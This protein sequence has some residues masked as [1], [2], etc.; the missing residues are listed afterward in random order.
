M[1]RIKEIDRINL[2]LIFLFLVAFPFGTFPGFIF[3]RFLTLPL[4]LHPIDVIIFILVVINLYRFKKLYNSVFRSLI[5]FMV[6]AALTLIFSLLK[7]SLKETFTG[8]LYLIRLGSYMYF[9]LM[10]TNLVNEKKISKKLLIDS[11]ALTG[12]II[13]ILGWLQY[14]LIPDLRTLKLF[15]WDDHYFRL[16]SSF[17]DPGFTGLIVVLTLVIF[18]LKYELK[19]EKTYLLPIFF[20]LPTLAFTYSRAS[21]LALAASLFYLIFKLK[22]IYLLVF[23]MV[24]V[25]TLYFLPNPGGEGVK[26]SRTSS[27]NA[28]T[29]NYSQALR[30]FRKFPVL[31][32]GYNNVCVAKIKYLEIRDPGAN[33]CSGFDNSYLFILSATGTVGFMVFLK[34]VYDLMSRTSKNF[35]GNI[36]IASGLAVFTHSLFVNSLFYAWIIG[37]IGILIAVSR[38]KT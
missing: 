18:I 32:V 23:F 2:F 33:S 19:K 26:L 37:W 11:L 22:K 6:V 20:L 3:S 8:F 30:L 25:L 15:G 35:Y 14:F 34:L 1:A 16:T 21:Y 29:L 7:F 5:W 17:L 13:G 31:G 36:F 9:V 38:D 27:I 28:R 10:L 12:I 24:L 4:R